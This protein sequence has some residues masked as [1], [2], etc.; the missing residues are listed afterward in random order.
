MICLIAGNKKEATL[1]AS[2]QN[3]DKSEWFYPDS[4]R[5]LLFRSNFHVVV[6]GT[7]GENIPS[8]LFERIYALA[9]MRG[10]VGRV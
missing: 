9:K 7:A 5:D 6:V 2:G 4:E 10:R 1:W 8:I 3:L